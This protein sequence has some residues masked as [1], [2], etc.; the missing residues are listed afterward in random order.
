MKGLK[1]E[2]EARTNLVTYS[3]DLSNAAWTKETGVTVGSPIS[4]GGLSLD[5][6]TNTGTSTFRNV[7]QNAGSTIADDGYVT[8]SAFIKAGDSTET[9]IRTDDGTTTNRFTALISWSASVPSISATTVL[10]LTE[11]GSGVEDYGGGLYRA[12][13]TARNETGGA[14]TLSGEYYVTW[15]DAPASG[16]DDTT[17]VGEIQLEAASTPSDRDWET[18]TV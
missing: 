3:G 15:D 5:L 12:W 7:S 18:S 17:Y 14:L 6:L 16:G 10:G 13:L 11:V 4:V 1:V 8:V 9:A 2:S